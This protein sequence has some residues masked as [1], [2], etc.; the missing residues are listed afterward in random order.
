MANI[1]CECGNCGSKDLRVRTSE[2]VGLRVGR[3]LLI[4]NNCGAKNHLMWENVKLETPIF[5]EREEFLRANKPLI[6]I[7]PRQNEIPMD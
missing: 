1:N 3:A 6:K 7:D 5:N 4:C 2:K